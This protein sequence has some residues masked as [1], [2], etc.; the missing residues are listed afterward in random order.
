MRGVRGGTGS[1]AL[2]PGRELEGGGSH[3]TAGKRRRIPAAHGHGSST[4]PRGHRGQSR[5]RTVSPHPQEMGALL[6]ELWGWHSA[7]DMAEQGGV[8]N[9]PLSP[10]VLLTG[11][12]GLGAAPPRGSSHCPAPRSSVS[13]LQWDKKPLGLVQ[14]GDTSPGHLQLLS[15]PTLPQL[16]PV[17]AT[18]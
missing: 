7:G 8:R 12:R 6:E 15:L 1:A 9:A 17:P 5:A 11:G 4:A 14:R 16:A 3:R 13:C 2:P 10:A 18:S